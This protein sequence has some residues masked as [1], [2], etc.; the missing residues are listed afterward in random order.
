MFFFHIGSAK[1]LFFSPPMNL[2]P[3]F[4]KISWIKKF[5]LS[6]CLTI[7][8]QH[9]RATKNHQK[10]VTFC[11]S[12]KNDYNQR[13]FMAWILNGFQLPQQL[14]ITDENNRLYFCIFNEISFTAAYFPFLLLYFSFF[15]LVQTFRHHEKLNSIQ[16][17]FARKGSWT[18]DCNTLLS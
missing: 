18:D 10:K 11:L 4:W 17:D 9:T 3:L 8:N 15:Q 16:M 12:N 2:G 14:C 13:N 6:V 1:I 5:V 7:N